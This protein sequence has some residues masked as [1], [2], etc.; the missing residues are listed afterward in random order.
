[1]KEIEALRS[2]RHTNIIKMLKVYE[3]AD[4]IN[5]VFEYL[6]GG[7]LRKMI[8]RK[9]LLKEETALKVFAQIMQGL[10]FLHSKNILHRDL[11]PANIFLE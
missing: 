7:D 1:M 9:K 6:G 10:S 11:K 3:T 4:S 2:V 8:I 5:L